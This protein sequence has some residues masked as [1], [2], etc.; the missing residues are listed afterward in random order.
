MIR[1]FFKNVVTTLGVISRRARKE[2]IPTMKW[3]LFGHWFILRHFPGIPL[4][5][6]K[7]TK[8]EQ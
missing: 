2:W 1:W 3:N 5:G 4:E 8:E 7:N 6:L